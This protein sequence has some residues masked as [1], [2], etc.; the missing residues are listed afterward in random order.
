MRRDSKAEDPN[1]G[2]SEVL[3]SEKSWVMCLSRKYTTMVREDVVSS[4]A[5]PARQ[6]IR[7]GGLVG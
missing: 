7:A 6:E 4:A 2:Q 5:R 1:G 3:G